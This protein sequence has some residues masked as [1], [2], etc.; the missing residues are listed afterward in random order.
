MVKFWAP[1]CN[2]CR[3]IAPHVDELQVGAAWA[4]A[5]C[6]RVPAAACSRCVLAGQ[7]GAG[8]CQVPCWT[9]AVALSGTASPLRRII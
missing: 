2:K 3:M 4:A 6:S 9:L 1:W 7:M 8:G 5:A